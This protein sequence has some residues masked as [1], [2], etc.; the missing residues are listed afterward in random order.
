MTRYQAIEAA[1]PYLRGR[2]VVCNL[3]VVQGAV[4]PLRS[5]EQLLYARK[6]GFSFLDRTWHLSL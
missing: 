4:F 6:Y 5:T 1:V 3:G 2:P